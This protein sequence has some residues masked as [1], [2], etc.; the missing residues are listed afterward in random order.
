MSHICLWLGGGRG[1]FTAAAAVAAFVLATLPIGVLAQGLMLL[2]LFLFLL[3]RSLGV[4]GLT[5]LALLLA[6]F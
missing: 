4:L 6:A 2:R 3:G 5:D 1:W